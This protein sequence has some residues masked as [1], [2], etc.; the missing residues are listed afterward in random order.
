MWVGDHKP[1]QLKPTRNSKYCRLHNY[2]IKTSKVV[3]CIKCGKGTYAKY[4]ACAKCGA[5]QIRLKYRYIYEGEC[6]RLR[7]IDVENRHIK[8]ILYRI[9]H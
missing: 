8:G 1:C 4:K 6:C 7:Q 9:A 5:Y 2:L 3:L